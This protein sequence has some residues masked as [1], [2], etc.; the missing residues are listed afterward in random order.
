MERAKPM[1]QKSSERPVVDVKSEPDVNDPQTSVRCASCGSHSATPHG[2]EVECI[3]A[4]RSEVER[5]LTILRP[6]RRTA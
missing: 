6:F 3:K 5:L 4:L 2:S 1:F